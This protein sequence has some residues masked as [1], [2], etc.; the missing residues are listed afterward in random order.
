MLTSGKRSFASLVLARCLHRDSPTPGAAELN[1]FRSA[2]ITS[3]DSCCSQARTIRA[4]TS[5]IVSIARNTPTPFA[6]C[7][8][9][10]STSRSLLPS[11]GGDFGF[12]NIATALKISPMLLEGYLTAALRISDLAVGDAEAEPGTA[13][14]LD[15]HGRHA[16]TAR[17]RIAARHAWRHARAATTSRQT[18]SMCSTDGS[19]AR[20]PKVMSASK[21]TRRRI[22]SSS[23]SMANRSFPRPSAARKTTSRVGKN[24]VISREEV[25]KRMTSPRIKVTAGP[26]D[27]GFTFID[28]P[29]AGTERV[30]AGPSRQP[31]SAQ[32][33][34][35]SATCA[36]ETSKVRTTSPASAKRRRGNV[37]S[38]ASRRPP[39]RKRLALPR[40][41]RL[42]RAAPS[43]GPSLRTDIEA[44]D[45]LL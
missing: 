6:I 9:S 44:A 16:E 13:T 8:A 30:A 20:L 36:R 41:C 22:N 29:A 26:H 5:C 10:M 3:L 24:I 28:R 45:D 1:R 31:G 17:G 25:D 42:L 35:Y 14:F 43:G 19:C 39:R 37:C 2:L 40:F 33:L 4:V 18:A 15:Q 38:P 32:S 12:D 7:W 23:P 11:D 34:G 27:V 21:V